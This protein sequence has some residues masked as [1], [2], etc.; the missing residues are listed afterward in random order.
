M[1]PVCHHFIHVH[2]ALRAGAGLP[3]HQRK[4][5]IQFS[6]QD[7]IAYFADEFTLDIIEHTQLIVGDGSCFFQISESTDDLLRHPVDVLRN[8]KIHDAALGLCAVVCISRN[9]NSSHGVFFG[10]IGNHQ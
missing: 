3:D 6:C 8:G 5:I 9:L 4:L 10:S 2:I 1:C 7:L